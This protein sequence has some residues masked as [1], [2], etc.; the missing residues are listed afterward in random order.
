MIDRVK[1]SVFI[2]ECGYINIHSSIKSSVAGS[3]VKV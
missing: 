3:R 2:K 1:P